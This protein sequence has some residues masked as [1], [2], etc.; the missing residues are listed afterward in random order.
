MIAERKKGETNF[1][2]VKAVDENIELY[3]MLNTDPQ[4]DT[5][6][7]PCGKCVGCRLEYSRQWANRLQ[8]ESQLYN[9]HHHKLK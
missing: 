7:L 5:L 8:L 2:F 1:A 3:H 6:L 4:F 9:A